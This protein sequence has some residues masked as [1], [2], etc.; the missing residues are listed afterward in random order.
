MLDF[1]YVT[2]P[3]FD[4]LLRLFY[5]KP[6]I[7]LWKLSRREHLGRILPRSINTKIRCTHTNTIQ[8]S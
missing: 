5:K 2:M 8:Y 3:A 7:K 1:I 6:L 4:H